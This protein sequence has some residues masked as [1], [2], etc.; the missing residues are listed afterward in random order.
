MINIEGSDV[1]LIFGHVTH[2]KSLQLLK[3]LD[4][5]K[6]EHNEEQEQEESAGLLTGQNQL[7]EQ[8]PALNRNPSTSQVLEWLTECRNLYHILS[9]EDPQYRQVEYL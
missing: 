7:L 4:L 1:T 5:C 8:T 6:T 3:R 2:A 9:E